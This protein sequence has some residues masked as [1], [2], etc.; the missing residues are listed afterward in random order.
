MMP[1][2]HL[3]AG[4]A[5]GA[6]YNPWVAAVL[7]AVLAAALA[8]VCRRGRSHPTQPKKAHSTH[9]HQYKWILV[10]ESGQLS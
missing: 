2:L 10:I 6:D 1:L 5:F 9:K 7:T 8:A 3:L 4:P